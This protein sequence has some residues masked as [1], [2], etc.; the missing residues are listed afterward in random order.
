VNV[1]DELSDIDWMPSDDSDAS[2][3]DD[4][5]EMKT[6]NDRSAPAAA[7]ATDTDDDDDCDVVPSIDV[8][9]SPVV[10]AG[11]KQRTKTFPSTQVRVCYLLTFF[12][13]V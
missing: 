6:G 4:D 8:Q 9:D 13:F 11:F 10:G 1:A 3:D 2:F 7:A 5:D 12:G